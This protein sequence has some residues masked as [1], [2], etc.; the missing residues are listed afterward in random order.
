LTPQAPALKKL[1]RRSSR[2]P[3]LHSTPP[4]LL[5]CILPL[6]T[7]LQFPPF[8]SSPSP[9]RSSTPYPHIQNPPH[10][11]S[12]SRPTPL[13]PPLS[14][15]PSSPSTTLHPFYYPPSTLTSSFHP[16]SLLHPPPPSGFPFFRP[17]ECPT[18]SHRILVGMSFSVRSAK[19][20]FFIFL[21]PVR[22]P[23]FA[24]LDPP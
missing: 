14:L 7:T 24:V 4:P 6:S 18:F 22:Y 19:V 3:H 17:T 21:S 10:P 16:V 9:I 8:P 5:H 15:S 11:T 2:H 1:H 12:L 13:S 20:P 23:A